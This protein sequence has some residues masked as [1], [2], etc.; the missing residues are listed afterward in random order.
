[1]LLHGYLNTMVLS[2]NPLFLARR[3]QRQELVLRLV[4]H[5]GNLFKDSLHRLL[6]L[7]FLH[8]DS[9]RVEAK[10]HLLLLRVPL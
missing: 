1:M 10:V 5:L 4:L 7:L 9:N 2:H 6:E 3:L 8:L